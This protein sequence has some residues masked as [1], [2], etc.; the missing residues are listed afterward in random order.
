MFLRRTILLALVFK[1]ASLFGQVNSAGGEQEAPLVSSRNPS[2]ITGYFAPPDE[3]ANQFGD[4][5]SPL[6]FNDGSWVETS[7]DWPRRRQ[8]ILEHWHA[9]MGK[10]PPLLEDQ[11]F[12]FESSEKKD[13][14][15]QHHVRFKWL[16]DQWT[17]GYLLVPAGDGPFP[18]VITVFYEPESAIGEGGKPHR[19][20]ALQLVRKGFVT[21]SIGTREASREKVFSL[22]HPSLENSSVEPLSLLACAA[23]NAWHSLAKVSSVDSRRIGITGHSFG[24]KWAMFASCLFDK[25]ACAAWSDP[26]IV[27][28]DTKGSAVNYWEPWYLGYYPPPWNDV[29][30]KEAKLETAKGN[31]PRIIQSGADLHELH[32]LMAPRPFLVSGGSSDPID[33]W[34]ALNH[35]IKVNRLLGHERR[36]A[37]T[38]RPEHSPNEFSNAMLCDFFEMMLGEQSQRGK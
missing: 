7:Q 25:F 17:D 18:A 6:Q 11:S 5:R 38:N 26:G 19:D 34:V 32:A 30:R 35:T 33:R 27:F 15:T 14:F 21:L 20:F 4:Y 2:Q 13:G 1:G 28:D 24:G 22:Y 29:W 31:Y 8:E 9:L 3:L 12:I 16:P 37:M 36:V 10:W 23:A